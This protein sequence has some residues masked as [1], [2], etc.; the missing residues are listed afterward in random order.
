MTNQ[1]ALPSGLPLLAGGAASAAGTSG[2]CPLDSRWGF[3]PDPE[4]LRISAS[5]A[6]GTR[7]WVLYNCSY[8]AAQPAKRIAGWAVFFIA[9]PIELF[10]VEYSLYNFNIFIISTS[11]YTRTNA[12]KNGQ[13]A[14]L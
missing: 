8:C 6:G 2:L 13:P 11:S 10:F 1:R 14:F 7:D 3:A 5:P 12:I 9:Y 4:M